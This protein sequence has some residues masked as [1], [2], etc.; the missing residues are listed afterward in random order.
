MRLM[1]GRRWA[2]WLLVL[3]AL[4]GLVVGASGY[5]MAGSFS[6]AQPAALAHW[7]RVAGAYLGLV[8]LSLLGITTGGVLLVRESRRRRAPELRAR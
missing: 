4:A 8:A 5:V 2:M 1:L 6:V 3:A 7:Q